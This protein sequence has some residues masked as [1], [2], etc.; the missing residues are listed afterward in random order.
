MS[1]ALDLLSVKSGTLIQ[2][3]FVGNDSVADASVGA[4][5]WELDT[6]GNAPTLS[7]LT[8]QPNGVLRHTTAATADGDGGTMRSLTDGLVIKPGVICR[9]RVRYPNVTGNQLAGNNFRVGLDDSVTATSPTVG[10]W[11]DSDA[12]VLSCQVDSADH[13]DE[14]ASVTGHPDLTSGTT[15]VL[16]DWTDLEFRCSGGENAQGGPEE[17]LFY[18]NG[19]FA[20]RVPCNIDDDEEV[21]LK[22]AHWQDSGAGADLELDIDYYEVFIPRS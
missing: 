15:M 18:V 9:A 20:A 4:L 5:G 7:I 3:D 19:G 10:I 8:A 13:G 16:D 22:I 1:S 6:I 17:V 11:F 2:E 14:S 12:G 21:E